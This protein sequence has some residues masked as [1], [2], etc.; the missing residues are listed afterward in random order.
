MLSAEDAHIAQRPAPPPI[1]KYR[2]IPRLELPAVRK[3]HSSQRARILQEKRRLHV[4][5][6]TRVYT[7]NY[8]VGILYLNI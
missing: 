4:E 6:C 3:F 7:G 1:L 5:Q 2:A 8:R